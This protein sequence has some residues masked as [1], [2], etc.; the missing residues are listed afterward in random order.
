M[1][2]KFT[3]GNTNWI[4]QNHEPEKIQREVLGLFDHT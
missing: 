2:D 4:G 1:G 3:Q